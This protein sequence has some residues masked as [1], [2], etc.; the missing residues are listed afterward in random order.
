[1][2]PDE[3]LRIE[4]RLFTD[5]ESLPAA[6]ARDRVAGGYFVLPGS[7]NLPH[8]LLNVLFVL[9]R[10]VLWIVLFLILLP[11]A[12]TMALIWKIK[13]SS[14]PVCSAGRPQRK[15]RSAALRRPLNPSQAQSP[16]NCFNNS[17]TAFHGSSAALYSSAT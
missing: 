13:E 15:G 10:L 1:M 16:F 6:G 8:E 17:G 14:W 7:I 2:L 9:D 4:A 12:V 3:T 11:V 5:P